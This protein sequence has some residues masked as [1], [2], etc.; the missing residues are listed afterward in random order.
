MELQVGLLEDYDISLLMSRCG[1]LLF[2]G[3]IFW[4]YRNKKRMT[5]ALERTNMT[6]YPI[7]ERG[8]IGLPE[9]GT[10]ASLEK[11]SE[12]NGCVSSFI[13]EHAMNWSQASLSERTRPK[14][15]SKSLQR[16]HRF[17]EG[18]K[19]LKSQVVAVALRHCQGSL[20]SGPS[21]CLRPRSLAD[22]AKAL[23]E[24]RPPQR[25]ASLLG[26]HHASPVPVPAPGPGPAPLSTTPSL[27]RPCL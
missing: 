21:I 8:G 16:Q 3:Q 2:T 7:S 25:G 5:E 17:T 20:E 10:C 1:G 14:H 22:G 19:R 12:G 26:P 23:V 27:L 9:T 15:F 11:S 18:R 24:T 13:S 4:C 6:L